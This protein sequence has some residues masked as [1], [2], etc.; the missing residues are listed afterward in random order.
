MPR[1]TCS[2]ARDTLRETVAPGLRAEAR[3]RAAMVAN[4]MA[5][6]VRELE[7]GPGT[8][9][10]ERQRLLDF[11]GSPDTTLAALRA[12][13]CRDLRSGALVDEQVGELRGLLQEFVQ[14][15]LAISNPGY[16]GS[17]KSPADQLPRAQDGPSGRDP[18]SPPVHSVLTAGRK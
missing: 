8:Q 7:L 12:R 11:Y 1:P 5:I 15:R 3:Y 4:A 9:A 13:L 10:A 14:A 18:P 17:Q 6:A 2:G 16:A